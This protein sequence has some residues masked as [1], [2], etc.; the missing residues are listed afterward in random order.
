MNVIPITKKQHVTGRCQD[1]LLFVETAYDLTLGVCDQFEQILKQAQLRLEESGYS[2]TQILSVTIYLTSFSDIQQIKQ[3]WQQW[4]QHHN[5][6]TLACLKS[7][8]RHTNCKIE[9]GFLVCNE[10]QTP[11]N[12]AAR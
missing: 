12:H 11:L 2:Q 5:S 7:E 10:H 6:A 3:V 8:M 1:T 4:K 9:V